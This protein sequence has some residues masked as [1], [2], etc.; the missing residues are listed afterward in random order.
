MAPLAILGIGTVL[1]ATIAALASSTK[2]GKRSTNCRSDGPAPQSAF[3]GGAEG[4]LY[5]GYLSAIMNTLDPRDLRALEKDLR[6]DGF[7]Y[8]A[9]QVKTIVDNMAGMPPEGS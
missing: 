9:D 3:P 4:S 6:K 1:A 7:C 5:R 8:E 2:K